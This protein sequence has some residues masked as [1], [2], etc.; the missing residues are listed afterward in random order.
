MTAPKGKYLKTQNIPTVVTFIAWCVA[1]YVFFL[2]YPSNTFE[3]L[4]IVFKGQ[5]SKDGFVVVFSPILILILTGVISSGNKARLVFWRL[6]NVLPGHRA[7]SKLAPNDPR[8]NIQALTKKIGV[9]P[10]TPKDQNSGWFALYKKYAEAVTVL[11]AHR[12]FLLAR[13]LCSI[14]FLFAVFGTCALAF[15]QFSLNGVLAYSFVMFLHYIVLAIV[16]QNHGNRF[17][18]NVI[19]EYISDSKAERSSRKKKVEEEVIRTS[20]SKDQT[21]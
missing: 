5:N 10:D 7:F 1:V 9:L 11:P 15:S 16:A 20:S 19:V 6:K 4:L 18:C 2:S 21:K 8:I 3:K 12:S 14:A 13:D 17:V